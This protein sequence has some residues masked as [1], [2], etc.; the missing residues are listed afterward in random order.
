MEREYIN[1][2]IIENSLTEDPT[3]LAKRLGLTVVNLRKKAS[4]LGIKKS[5]V[6]NAV[7]DGKKLCP[8]CG[9]ML[10]IS[11]FNKDKY[12]PNGLDYHC[13]KCRKIKPKKVEL[14]PVTKTVSPR[15]SK[16]VKLGVNHNRLQTII[17][18]GIESRECKKCTNTKPLTE[19]YT[20]KGVCKACI[21]EAKRQRIKAKKEGRG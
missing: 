3:K 20:G 10:E 9:K 2:Q 6:T 11:Q 7:I 8:C 15:S 21:L 4:R 5:T 18:N 16:S 13:K 1:Q 12:Q 17:V 14:K 19:F